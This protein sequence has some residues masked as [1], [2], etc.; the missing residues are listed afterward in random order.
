MIKVSDYIIQ[1]LASKG[2]NHPFLLPGGQS[3]HL[4]N[5]IRS[6]P[7][8]EPVTVLHEQAASMMAETYSRITNNYG[9][10]VVSTGPGGTNCVTGLIGAWLDSTPCMFISGQFGTKNL[11]QKKGIKQAALAKKGRFNILRIYRRF[12]K[13]DE[14]KKIT[15]DMRYMDRKYKL[16][17]TNDICG[18]SNKK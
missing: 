18:K 12:K 3:M 13:V 6:N 1:Y 14:C 11:G 9:L 15:H 8:M 2:V 7:D 16:G 10:C 17:K 4:V 5:S